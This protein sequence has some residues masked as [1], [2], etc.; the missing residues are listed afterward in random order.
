MSRAS[1]I[2][3]KIWNDTTPSLDSTNENAPVKTEALALVATYAA[4]AAVNRFSSVHCS[5]AIPA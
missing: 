5:V 2:P 4:A 3:W 1:L